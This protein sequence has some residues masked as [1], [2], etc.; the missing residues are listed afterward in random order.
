MTRDT[1][2]DPES[3][4]KPKSTTCDLVCEHVSLQRFILECLP[5]VDTPC[6]S[7]A[8]RESD[9]LII[10]QDDEGWSFEHIGLSDFQS[11]A[12]HIDLFVLSFT[13][14]AAFRKS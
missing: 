14:L 4:E 1:S 7:S 12:K 10:R 13:V 8:H 3:R 11:R 2:F 9:A 5:H 6:D